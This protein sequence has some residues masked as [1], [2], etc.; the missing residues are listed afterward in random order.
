MY[1][2][3]MN[4][5]A[6]KRTLLTIK[7]LL[8]S[9][10]FFGQEIVDVTDQTIKIGSFQE[11][12]LYFGFAAGDKIVFS[13]NEVGGKELKELEIVEYPNNSKFSDFKTSQIEN[14]S[15]AVIEEG[16]YFF[17]FKNTAVSGRVCNIKIQRIPASEES[18][19]FNTKVIWETRQET[20]Y[21]TYTK[22]VIVGYDTT[23][24]QKTRKVLLSS[25]REEVMIFDK[26]Q[27]VHSST[28][29]NGNKSSLFFTLPENKTEAYK[30][31]TVISWAYWVGVGEEASQAWKQNV[32]ALGELAKG[33]ANYLATPLGALAVGTVADL[34]VPN[35]GEDV[36]YAITDQENK[37]LYFAGY[38]YKLLDQG[39]GVA[40]FRK[41]SNPNMCQGTYFV[42]LSNDN[43]VQAIDAHV[44]VI[45]IVETKEFKDEQ[46]TEMTVTPRYEKQVFSDPIVTTFEV[47]VIA[48]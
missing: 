36:Y 20:S 17:R 18:R 27:R 1:I 37:N 31:T 35:V 46:Y 12:V 47:P 30:T 14:K 29:P 39:K 45:A 41:F 2:D 16:V 43:M 11:E 26:P 24:T 10:I 22:D 3:H 25:E 7:V 5:Q 4:A 44:K 40:G 23:Y 13:F 42:L 48:K 38:Q 33:A 19:D 8:W 34:M 15:I 21:N 28:N 32:Q 6:L 9:T